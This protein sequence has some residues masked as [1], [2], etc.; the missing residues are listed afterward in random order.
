MKRARLSLFEKYEDPGYWFLPGNESERVPGIVQYDPAEGITLTLW[1]KFP[2]S[3]NSLY[4]RFPTVLGITMDRTPVTILDVFCTSPG[5]RAEIN[6]MKFAAQFLLIGLHALGG[7]SALFNQVAASYTNLEDWTCVRPIDFGV[8]ESAWVVKS[9]YLDLL[10]G[11]IE[12]IHASY[13]I[14][15]AA[16]SEKLGLYSLEWQFNSEHRPKP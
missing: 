4:P 1:G 10:E 6:E 8:D 2:N 14:D 5:T 16:R 15:P 7:Q 13:I 9:K 11:K 3:D 12:S